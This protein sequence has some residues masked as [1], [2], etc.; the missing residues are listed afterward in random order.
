MLYID[1]IISILLV[2]DEAHPLKAANK[3]LISD[4]FHPKINNYYNIPLK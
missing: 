3:S 1:K 4:I 2:M